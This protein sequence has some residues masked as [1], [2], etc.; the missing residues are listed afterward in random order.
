MKPWAEHGVCKAV[1]N[2][3]AIIVVAVASYFIGVAV[4]QIGEADPA[5]SVIE[6]ADPRPTDEQ[7]EREINQI[8]DEIQTLARVDASVN[9]GVVTLSGA[10]PTADAAARAQDIASRVNGVVTVENEIER[11]VSVDSRIAPAIDDVQNYAEDAVKFAPLAVLAFVV[12]SLIAF[13]GQLLSRWTGFWRRVTPNAFIAEIAATTIRVVFLVLASIAALSLL[14]ATALL[15]AFLGAAG[16]FGLAIG[17]AIRDTMEN[18]ISSIMLSLRQP[19]RPNDHVVIDDKEGLVIRL[20]SRATILMTM[21]GNHLRI[22]NST[23][24]KAIIL[25]YTRNSERRFEFDL[26]V[27]ADDDPLAAIETGADAIK[28]LDFVL[29]EPAPVGYIRNVG[30]SNIVIRFTAW[31]D[32]NNSDF[33]KSRSAALSAAK[34]ALEEAGFALPEPIYRLRF[35]AAAPPI[36]REVSGANVG[37]GSEEPSAPVQTS[38]PREPNNKDRNVAVDTAPDTHI[39]DKVEEERRDACEEDL[40]DDAAPVE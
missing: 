9:A 22:P 6:A 39:A 8:F 4:A 14:D 13:S 23:V 30:D 40:L 11:D 29:R 21:D 37:S 19:F 12:F 32:Q 24:F 2:L 36:L 27:D 20:T 35:D 34:D 26:G 3:T 15:G 33:R 10:T 25:N 38:R 17:F 1:K 28:A 5:A 7:I 16:L 18:Y 31:V